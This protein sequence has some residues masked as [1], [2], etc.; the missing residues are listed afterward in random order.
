M[1]EM[2][3]SLVPVLPLL[4]RRARAYKGST[5]L[6]LYVNLS[7]LARLMTEMTVSRLRVFTDS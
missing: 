7:S 6:F 5:P 3:L 2:T 1:T 4:R